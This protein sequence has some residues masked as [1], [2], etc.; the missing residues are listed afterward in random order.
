MD[1]FETKGIS[2]MLIFEQ[3]EP[4]N[5]D[6]SIFELK[7]DGIRC[8]A[9]CDSQSV[10]LQNKRDMKLLPRFPELNFLHTACREKCILDGEL[11]VL[12]NGNRI[13]MRCRNAYFKTIH[14]RLSLQ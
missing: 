3:V 11:N 2:P 6:N 7:L 10:D 5:D 14:L 9:Y 1:I 13:S 4:Y 12:V 8:I